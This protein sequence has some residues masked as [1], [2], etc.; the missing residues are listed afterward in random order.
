[1]ESGEQR[2]KKCS[3]DCKADGEE[4]IKTNSI[5]QKYH[6]TGLEYN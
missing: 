6:K 1:M 5:H 3:E 2:Y 4:D